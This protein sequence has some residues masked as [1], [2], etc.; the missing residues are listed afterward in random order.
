MQAR[1]MKGTDK[2][3]LGKDSSVP[4]TDPDLGYPKVMH[5]ESVNGASILKIIS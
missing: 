1:F 3:T 2:S 5:L 4:L